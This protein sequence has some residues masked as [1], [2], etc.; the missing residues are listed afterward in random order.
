M[1]GQKNHQNQRQ[2]TVIKDMGNKEVENPHVVVR[3]F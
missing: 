1:Y 3:D 2:Y